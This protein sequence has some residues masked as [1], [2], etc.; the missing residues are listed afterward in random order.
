MKSYEFKISGANQLSKVIKLYKEVSDSFMICFLEDGII[1]APG[2]DSNM[3]ADVILEIP[4]KK[5]CEIGYVSPESG[6]IGKTLVISMNEINLGTGKLT[7]MFVISADKGEETIRTNMTYMHPTDGLC[8]I[9][10]S[11]IQIFEQ[12]IYCPFT[13]DNSATQENQLITT[14]PNR[15][16]YGRVKSINKK[17]KRTIYWNADEN[18]IAFV[19]NDK[20]VTYPQEVDTTDLYTCPNSSISPEIIEILNKTLISVKEDVTCVMAMNDRCWFRYSLT[21]CGRIMIKV[22]TN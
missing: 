21:G 11:V 20:V 18:Y 17:I 7:D 1:I 10:P 16:L 15:F 12:V 19:H 8:K 9:Q 22:G 4:Y 14:I 2:I 13:L 6:L 3:Y 5:M